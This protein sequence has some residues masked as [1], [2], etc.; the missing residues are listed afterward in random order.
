MLKRID[1]VVLFVSDLDVSKAFYRDQLGLKL[2]MEA[3]GF[4]E[5]ELDNTTIGLLSVSIAQSLVPKD[6]VTTGGAQQVR[7]QLAAF[8]DDVR[9][10]HEELAGRGV[11]FVKKPSDQPWGQRTANFVDPDGHLW[12]ISQW[13]R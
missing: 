5:F 12:E 6:L 1:A 13:L 4:A 8:V 9:K 3:E 7:G 11:P 2:K 10:T